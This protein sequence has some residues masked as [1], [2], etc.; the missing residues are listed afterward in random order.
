[1]NVAW[2]VAVV[3]G[4]GSLAAAPAQATSPIRTPPRPSPASF[5]VPGRPFAQPSPAAPQATALACAV[6]TPSGRPLVFSPR[7]G[8]TPRRVTARGH[9]ELTGCT[10]P[11]GSATF[12][13]SGW[14]SVR[15]DA[16]ASCASARQ[17]RGRAVITW[18]GV[19][20]RPLGT[21]TLRIRADRLVAQQPAD[22]LLTGD[23]SAGRLLG[24]HVRGG[25]TPPAAILGCATQG[26]AALPGHGRITFG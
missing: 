14:A 12:L 10:S 22:T 21:S 19:T 11:D 23:V 3:A 9:L 13:R 24:K 6:S 5:Q 17:V 25:I 7:V 4:A 18:F 8:L 2:I 20:G 1:M 15:A 26:M 16:Q